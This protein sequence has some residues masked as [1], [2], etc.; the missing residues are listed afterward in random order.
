M[1]L[2]ALRVG[3]APTCLLWCSAA[4]PARRGRGRD[5]VTDAEQTYRVQPRKPNPENADSL[6]PAFPEPGTG[7]AFAD[8]GHCLRLHQTPP[9]RRPHEPGLGTSSPSHSNTCPAGARGRGTSRRDGLGPVGARPDSRPASRVRP[10]PWVN[11]LPALLRLQP[12]SAPC[13]SGPDPGVSGELAVPLRA[14]IQ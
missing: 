2:L 4:R 9:P 5:G 14:C 1:W 8:T 12:G 11:P 13:G 3:W 7:A 6:R 10:A